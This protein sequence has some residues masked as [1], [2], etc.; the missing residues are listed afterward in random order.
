VNYIDTALLLIIIG[1]LWR[2]QL[3]DKPAARRGQ[4]VILDS[5]GLIDG[6]ILDIKKAGFI[7]AQLVIPEFILTELQ[8]LADGKDAHKRERARYGLEVAKQ[9]REAPDTSVAIL[10]QDYPTIRTVDDKLIALSLQLN[11]RLY[12]TDYNLGKVAAIKNVTVLNVNE[13]AQH[14]RPTA[15][16]G[17]RLTVKLIQKGQTKN[18][19]VGYLEDGTMVVVDEADRHIGKTI[20]VVAT[21]LHQT[22]SGKMIFAKTI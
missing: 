14:L 6:R 8:L 15:L 4:R 17:E 13:L 3:A 1:L 7:E 5:C 16:P 19:G 11:A 18:Q 9:L 2:R 21:R 12:T 22:E 20:E 10:A